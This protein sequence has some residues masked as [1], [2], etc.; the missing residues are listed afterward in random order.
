M[1]PWCSFYRRWCMALLPL[2]ASIVML[3]VGGESMRA[4][5][6]GG[7][8]GRKLVRALL[9]VQP[10]SETRALIDAAP[11]VLTFQSVQNKKTKNF[12]GIYF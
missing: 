2:P 8:R 5:A 4:M 7:L 12:L 6:R 3:L 9:R 10:S 11:M 1:R